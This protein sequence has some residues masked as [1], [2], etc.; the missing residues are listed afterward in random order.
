MMFNRSDLKAAWYSLLKAPSYAIT[1]VLSIGLP[2][3]V[4]LVAGALNYHV[5]LAPLPYPQGEQMVVAK[6]QLLKDGQLEQ[7]ETFA[8]PALVTLYQDSIPNQI[9]T[10]E[11]LVAYGS[12]LVQNLAEKPFLATSYITPG[13]GNLLAVPMQLGRFFNEQEQLNSMQPVAVLSHHSWQRDFQSDPKVLE[14]L[15]VL[16]GRSFQII[17]VTAPHFQEPKLLG[18]DQNSTALWLPFDFNGVQPAERLLWSRTFSGFYLLAKTTADPSLLSRQWSERLNQQFGLETQS[19]KLLSAFSIRLELVSLRDKITGDNSQLALLLFLASLA[20]MGAASSNAG[21]LVLTR[22]ARLQP[23]LAIAAALGANQQQVSG[24]LLA[25]QLLLMTA[26]LV[27]ATVT[28]SSLLP[29][30][31]ELLSPYIANS[32][33]LALTWH[34]LVFILLVLTTLTLLFTQLLSRHCHYRQLTTHFATGKSGVFQYQ[35][36]RARALLF[37]QAGLAALLLLVS[38]Q[39]LQQALMHLQ[40]PLGFQTAHRYLVELHEGERLHAGTPQQIADWQAIRQ[41][42]LQQPVVSAVSV[43]TAPPIH[44]Y[45]DN[46]WQTNVS[47]NADFN[48]LNRTSGAMI[49]EHYLSVLKIALLAGRNVSKQDV[50]TQAKVVLLNQKLANRLFPGQELP[51]VIGKPLYWFNSSERTTP[52]QVIGVT[53]DLTLPGIAETGRLFIPRLQPSHSMLLVTMKADAT[54]TS[55]QLNQW[56]EQVQPQYAV[57]SLLSLEQARQQL[58]ANDSITAI[59][60]AS[61]SLLVVMLTSLG[62]YGV[63]SYSVQ[64]RR[65]ELGVRMAIGA[66][67]FTI[68]HQLL[69]E[70]LQPVLA[71]LVMAALLLVA[72]WLGLQHTTFIVDLSASGFVLPLGLIVLLTTL[73][74]LLSVWGIIRKPAIYALQGQ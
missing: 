9:T 26:A 49:D 63:L 43:T 25:E 33:K 47:L 2:L 46:Q 41:H 67:P 24:R 48:Q 20:L 1:L 70:N 73:T 60:T 61:L 22:A 54:L 68:V 44:R 21:H 64:L 35:G 18:P 15:L 42:L 50:Q 45:G 38:A 57:T 55:L 12:E 52:Y 32:N 29:F 66:R 28:A 30:S 74:S 65:F 31:R 14:R 39:L 36:R 69:T 53:A 19:I 34:S 3:G 16:N 51:D 71:G 8:Y 11:T 5:L 37:V 7:D 23:H 40:Q 72:L 27:L 6:G 58:V 56:L 17:G 59:S 10:D 62:I 13:Y 4:L